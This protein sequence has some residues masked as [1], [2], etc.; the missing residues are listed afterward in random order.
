MPSAARRA[1]SVA[2]A[3]PGV[4]SDASGLSG[5][6]DVAQRWAVLRDGLAM[7][8]LPR[9]TALQDHATGAWY[10][11]DRLRRR[12]VV[13]VRNDR[14]TTVAQAYIWEATWR[15]QCAR[16]QHQEEQGQPGRR[17]LWWTRS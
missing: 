6:L 11:F 13:P 9:F 3:R 8:P 4:Y 12:M 2:S 17:W 14:D 10:L 7:D 5:L 15:D 1:H 16:W